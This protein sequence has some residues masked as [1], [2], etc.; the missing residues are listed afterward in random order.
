MNT[1]HQNQF[2]KKSKRRPL[3]KDKWISEFAW[4]MNIPYSRGASWDTRPPQHILRGVTGTD[5]PG[6]AL[7][8]KTPRYNCS[9]HIMRAVCYLDKYTRRSYCH[10]VEVAIPHGDLHEAVHKIGI[11]QLLHRHLQTPILC[12]SRNC[13][14]V[15]LNILPRVPL[16]PIFFFLKSS[17]S[18]Q[19]A[20]EM[21]RILMSICCR[22]TGLE[23]S[24]GNLGTKEDR[25]DNLE[26]MAIEGSGVRRPK[27]RM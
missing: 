7:L 16:R 17:N 20:S 11:C 18:S 6:V 25:Q 4:E 12:R 27:M 24:I 22:R 9:V 8:A 13:A 10:V 14:T 1:Q 19:V 15:L 21:R 23:Y 3:R 5:N 2:G 26:E